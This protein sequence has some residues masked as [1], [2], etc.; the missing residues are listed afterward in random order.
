MQ[1]GNTCI[2]IIRGSCYL[3]DYVM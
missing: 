1:L 2:Y 3:T